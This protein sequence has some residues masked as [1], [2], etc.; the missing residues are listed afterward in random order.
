[1]AFQFEDDPSR[2]KERPVV[3][4]AKNATDVEVLVLSV[5]VT[6]HP[7][8]PGIPGEIPLLDWEDAGLTRPST[9]RC[10]KYLLIPIAAFKAFYR[11]GR[12]SERDEKAVRNALLGLKVLS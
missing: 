6:S 2:F 11:Y 9:V 3:I 12:L 10:S 7:P 1:M 5:K 4:A 8:R